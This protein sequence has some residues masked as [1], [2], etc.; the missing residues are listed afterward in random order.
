MAIRAILDTNYFLHFRSID[1]I[2]WRKELGDTDTRLVITAICL[3]ELERKKVSDPRL[4]ARQRASS[5]IARLLELSDADEP[6]TRSGVPVDFLAV[7]PVEVLNSQP[8]DRTL[9]DDVLIASAIKVKEGEPSAK[10]VIV[11]DDAGVLIKCKQ[12][13]LSRWRPTPQM[14]LSEPLDEDQRELRRLREEN[15]RLLSAKPKLNLGLAGGG[16]VVL[17]SAPD[18]RGQPT[19]PS[20]KEVKKQYPPLNSSSALATGSV[21]EVLRYNKNINRYYEEYATFLTELRLYH[22]WNACQVVVEFEVFNEGSAPAEDLDIELRFDEDAVPIDLAEGPQAPEE[23][24]LPKRPMG[25]LERISLGYKFPEPHYKLNLPD[26]NMSNITPIT[27][28]VR[29][30]WI[31]SAE[32]AVSW[33]I[34]R[35]KHLELLRLPPVTLLR[36]NHE[37][38]GAKVQYRLH[39]ANLPEIITG[40]FSFGFKISQEADK[41][42]PL[43][44][45]HDSPLI[46]GE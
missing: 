16:G 19:H 23:P 5:V 4:A 37:I 30:P 3:R 29:G 24:E 14:R 11:S 46:S 38:K 43:A 21:E 45:E 8:L 26:F 17:V 32:P 12:F 31:L 42:R 2:D 1:D 15:L 13:G 25:I 44:D 7:E 6:T 39:A 33:H 20:L 35:L 10:V 22:E 36:K 9:Y 28:N 34:R 27:A 18:S 41:P 40:S